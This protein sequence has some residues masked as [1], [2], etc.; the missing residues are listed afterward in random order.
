MTTP[1][2]QQERKK[3]TEDMIARAVCDGLW[4]FYF[5]QLKL[6][7]LIAGVVG[8]FYW[9]FIVILEANKSMRW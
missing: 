7:V 3:H 4:M 6:V 8:V 1:D 5:Q 9:V 2:A